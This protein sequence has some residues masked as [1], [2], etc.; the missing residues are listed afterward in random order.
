MYVAFIDPVTTIKVLDDEM[1]WWIKSFEGYIHKKANGRDLNDEQLT[2]L[3]YFFKSERLNKAERYTIALTADNNHFSV[4]S[5]MEAWGL[6]YKHPESPQLYPI[7]IVNRALTKFEFIDELRLLFGGSYDDLKSEIKEV[8]NVI[9]HFNHFGKSIK[10]PNA[11][12]VGNFLFFRKYQVVANVEV[13]NE[14]K[15]KIRRI[16]NTLTK[17]GFLIKSGEGPRT[18]HILN[19]NF[20]R[21]NSLFE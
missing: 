15:R 20:K 8:L 10:N 14:F 1:D 19:E 9:Y 4:I 17:S 3:A 2:A 6:I 11:S 5:D 13:F 12:Q 18:S 21:T 16:V 7:Y